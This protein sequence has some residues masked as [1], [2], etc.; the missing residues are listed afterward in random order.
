MYMCVRTGVY[1]DVLCTVHGVH[2][3]ADTAVSLSLSRCEGAREK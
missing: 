3:Y 1:T 2:T